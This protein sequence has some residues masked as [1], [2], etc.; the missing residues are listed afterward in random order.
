MTKTRIIRIISLLLAMITLAFAVSCGASSCSCKGKKS[1]STN[2]SNSP[3]D[4]ADQDIQ[5][6][7]EDSDTEKSTKKS[8]RIC[9]VSSSSETAFTE[10]TSISR[11]KKYPFSTEI[12]FKALANGSKKHS[13]ISWMNK[14]T[15]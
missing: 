4:S 14:Y 1:N 13:R 5:F 2:N 10:H 8:H 7:S 6:E 3:S 11:E 12:T 15:L 9:T